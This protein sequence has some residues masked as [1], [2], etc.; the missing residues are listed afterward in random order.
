MGNF[1]V[2]KLL[3][4]TISLV[5]DT[6]LTYGFKI[7]YAL[8]IL[9]FGWLAAKYIRTFI[10][11][12]MTKKLIDQTITGFVTNLTYTALLLFVTLFALQQL[13]IETT[14]FVA[15]L[16]AAGLAIGL[17]LQGTMSNFASGFLTIIFRPFKVGDYIVGAGVGGTVEEIS[18]FTTRLITPDNKTIIIPNSKLTGDIIVNHTAKGIRRI[19]LTAIVGCQNEIDKV[20]KAIVNVLNKDQRILMEPPAQIAMLELSDQNFKFAIRPWV[21]IAD[22]G[23]VNFEIIENIKKRLDEESIAILTLKET[24]I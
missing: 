3:D 22:Y 21:K 8:A 2:A 11:K 4:K 14:S 12:I 19:D 13:G 1:D 20:K 18:I 10:N 15:I 5:W 6:V 9:I 16:G 24:P 7:I 23:S 17:A